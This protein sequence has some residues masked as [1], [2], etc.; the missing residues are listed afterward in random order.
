MTTPTARRRPSSRCASL[1]KA[2]G[3]VHVPADRQRG[4]R[5]CAEISQQQ[6]GA[7]APGLDRCFPVRGKNYPWTIALNPNYQSEGRIYAKYILANHPNAKIGILYQNDD[8]GRD[9]VAGLKTGLG[10]K[11]SSMI[12]GEVSYEVA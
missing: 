7:A 3:P 9:Y 11:A 1:S 12:V 4:Q 8:M 5:R 6:E 10:E 2:M